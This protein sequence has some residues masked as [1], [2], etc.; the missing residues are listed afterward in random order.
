MFHSIKTI[1]TGLTLLCSKS[2]RIQGRF[3]SVKDPS[4][5][6]GKPGPVPAKADLWSHRTPGFVIAGLYWLGIAVVSLL[7]SREAMAETAVAPKPVDWKITGSAAIKEAFDSNV[8][9]QSVTPQANQASL[10]TTLLPQLM[11]SWTPSTAFTASLNYSPEITFFHSESSENY[12]L[13]RA[14]LNLS[15]KVGNTA[16]EVATSF[17]D[18]NG[19]SVGPT[20]TGPGGAPA[21]GGPAVRDRRD[22]DVYR[23]SVR[24]T[25]RFEQWFVRPVAALYVHD[26]QTEQ[27]NVA[28][29]QNY[30]DRREIA[31]GI[32]VGYQF[33]R[34]LS[35]FAGYRYGAQ[36]QAKLLQ[37]PEEYDNTYQ[38]VLLGC[39]G[40]PARWLKINVT[41]G[42]ELRHYGDKVPSTFGDHEVWNLFVDAS[43]TLLP[44]DADTLIF[45]VRQFE[46]PG[47]GGRSAYD[48][49]TYD[50]TWK[51]KLDK[52]WTLGLGARAYNTDFLYPVVRN[53]WVL[54]GNG[55]V[56]FVISPRWSVESS[57]V[58]EQGL[59]R[60][61][62]TS[63][64]EY[65]RHLVA[66]GIKGIFP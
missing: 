25:S 26:F 22:A 47:F 61:S 34:P 66:L 60:I 21:A 30:V 55:L 52:R 4:F 45:C 35:V 3:S 59:S 6:S 58:Y 20:W 37:F 33:E 2:S 46:Q 19:S 24:F 13:Q 7:A 44:T 39:E 56:N 15:G 17:V 1:A 41:L 51:R 16:Y 57:Y 11:G 63:G 49:L 8:Y 43:V 50:L 53:D 28:G 23:S 27:R 54:S 64:R 10:V 29:Y 48:D 40:T 9:L 14:V 5:H 12:V 62:G 32:D 42:P 31:G 18:I 38:R 36:D 65:T